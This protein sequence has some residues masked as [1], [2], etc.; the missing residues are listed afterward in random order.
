MPHVEIIGRLLQGYLF[1][2]V[3]INLNSELIKL[4]IQSIKNDLQSRNP[5]HVNLALQCIANI[6]SKDMCEAFTTE[7]PKLLVSG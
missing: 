7:L 1:I 5:V 2:S 6:G 4:I 3:L